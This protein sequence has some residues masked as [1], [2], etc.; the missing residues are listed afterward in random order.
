VRWRHPGQG[1]FRVRRLPYSHA[2]ITAAVFLFLAYLVL[3][4]V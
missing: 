3:G 1:D 4:G 2:A